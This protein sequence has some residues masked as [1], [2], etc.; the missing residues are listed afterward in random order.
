LP[1]L[2]NPPGDLKELPSAFHDE[3]S[4]PATSAGTERES[5]LH[6]ARFVF[7]AGRSVELQSIRQEVSCYAPQDI[8]LW[9]P[10]HPGCPQENGP[11][12]TSIASQEGF[13]VEYLTVT[14]DLIEQIRKAEERD[15]VVIVVVD[16]W[17]LKIQTY[18]QRVQ[19]YD[20][21]N[22]ANSGVLVIWNEM[23]EETKQSR[24]DLE[25]RIQK[26]LWRNLNLYPT[27]NVRTSVASSDQLQTELR[28]LLAEVRGRL[29]KRAEVR[30]PVLLRQNIPTLPVPD[31][32][33]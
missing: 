7:I 21:R 15:S 30:R 33:L 16:P 25:A 14:S 22:F 6:I 5:E 13:V 1:A 4:T 17:T 27:T 12:S 20:E 26:V 19:E 29:L 11:L 23:D 3:A 18:E 31:R 8:R 2:P 9:R 24:A 10:Y 28:V 32:V